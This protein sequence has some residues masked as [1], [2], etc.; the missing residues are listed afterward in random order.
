MVVEAMW[1]RKVGIFQSYMMFCSTV[2]AYGMVHLVHMQV[3]ESFFLLNTFS[4]WLKLAW[5]EFQFE[6]DLWADNFHIISRKR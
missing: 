2:L 3:I 5:K 1:L 4:F 6:R